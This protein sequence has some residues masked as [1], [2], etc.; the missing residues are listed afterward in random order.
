MHL[1][2]G[3]VL[4]REVVLILGEMLGEARIMGWGSYLYWVR[5]QGRDLL[6]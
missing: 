1:L 3:W 2:D 5:R 6:K 4:M